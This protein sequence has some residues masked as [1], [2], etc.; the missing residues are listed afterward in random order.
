[1]LID[2]PRLAVATTLA[3]VYAARDR[4][5]GAR[6][7]GGGTEVIADQNL[8]LFEPD[9]YV[10]LRRVPELQ[11]ITPVDRGLR[12]GA[13]VTIARLLGEPVS[14]T[15]PL[16]A[17]AART[18]GT[19]QVRN[20]ATVGGNVASGLPD[21]T[22]VP[23]LLA[24]EAR[25]HVGGPSGNRELPIAEFLVGPGSTALD[26]DEIVTAVTVPSVAGFQDYTMVGPRNAQ[27]FPTVAVALVVDEAARR[28]RLGLGNAGPTACRAVEAEDFAGGAIDWPGRTVRD[29]VAI[30]FGRL[31]AEHCDPPDDAAA[32]ADYRRH[33]LGVMARRILQRAFEEAA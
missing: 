16:L 14:G 5:P 2:S 10:S 21:R 24:L 20:R 15:T 6:V 23:C 30:G 7:L 17:R 33:A 13:G 19:R 11:A 4:M 32:T 8:E 31:T 12:I 22:L 3:E 18:L 28:V 9:G 29:E 25:V 26:A 1:M 27:F